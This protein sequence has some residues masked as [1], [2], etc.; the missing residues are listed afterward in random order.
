M[1]IGIQ[2]AIRGPGLPK[3]RSPVAATIFLVGA[4]ALVVGCYAWM[5]AVCVT[6][7]SPNSPEASH[8]NLLVEGF[9]HGQLSLN[10]TPPPELAQLAD[11]Y[12]PV[13]N[14]QY[15]LFSV[16]SY[17]LHDMSYYK[18]KLYL[19][20]GV[21]PALL[22]FWPWA[23]LTGH[24]LA[25][26]HAVAVF[27]AVGFLAG[28]ALLRALWRRYFPEVGGAVVAAGVL[29]L[30]L[31]SGVLIVQQRAEVWEVPISCGYALSM[32]A[33]AAVWLALHNPS[34][35]G[36]W[37]AA[38]SLAL[39]LAV[40]ARP[41]LLFGAAILLVPLAQA[42]RLPSPSGARQIPWGLLAAAFLPLVL[43][44]LGLM[45]Y[46]G[47]RFDNPF[48]FGQHYQ[49]AGD[50]QDTARHFSPS[51]LWYNFR[52]YFL[53][54]VRWT[55]SLPFVGDSVSPAAPLGHAKP[56][57]PFGVLTNIPLVW[58]ALAM[59]LAWR[60]RTEEAR[61]MLRGFFAAA[62]ILFGT[63]ASILCLFYGTCSRYELEF[64][65]ELILLAAA[66]ILGVERALAG[67][68]RWRFAARVGWGLL[69]SFSVLFNVLASL[70]R[71]AVQ[72]CVLGASL[73]RSGRT[74]EAVVS[75]E[76]A[77]RFKP[78]DVEAHCGLGI[79]LRKLGRVPEAIA[80]YREA[81]RL[82]PDS[83]A[84]HTGLGNILTAEGRTGE[85]IA[86]HEEALRLDPDLAEAHN[87]LGNALYAGGRRREA[88]G[89]Y[90]AALRLQPDL[91][92]AHVNLG[93][94]LNTEDRAREA[95]E[96]YEAALRLDPDIAQA[97]SNLGYDLEKTPGRLDDAI[98]QYEAA[99]RLE[100]NDVAVHYNLGNALS[101]RGRTRE[102]IGQYEEALRLNPDHLAARFNLAVVLLKTPGG[103][104]E[105]IAQLEAIV[106]LQPG[107]ERA[108]RLLARIRNARP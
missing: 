87:N 97:H 25:Q 68:P 22:L 81:L 43:C 1:G 75:F 89:Q 17:G 63:S 72:R 57:D 45:L 71:Y 92:Q 65:P 62:A 44:G 11:P 93:N 104:D 16:P 31:A 9:Q 20:F 7:W 76:S 102:A 77:L 13:A 47:L 85:A 91:A 38:A 34:R 100:P 12:D 27:C 50:R 36:W 69:L 30:G 64:L 8:Y 95:I 26:R 37:L 78:D 10:K 98:T 105:A 70:D 29:A 96:Q 107:N 53:E 14:A 39:G 101:A 56:E 84:A 18:G 67:R 82:K 103:A 60:N 90:E 28:A 33:L 41:S 48:E 49:L 94:V 59:P 73:D 108:A 74:P 21:T 66:G 83:A 42:W 5:G 23:A 52:V 106:R 15:R 55:R 61:S 80:E 58:L 32:L 46:N 6:V 35:R 4:F 79:A 24:Y 2:Q 40:G 86:E 99:L 3:R 88:I 19:Y 54:A 51:Y